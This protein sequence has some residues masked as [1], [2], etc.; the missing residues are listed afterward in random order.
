MVPTTPAI[1]PH[2]A[3]GLTVLFTIIYIAPFY[4]SPT[5]RSNS[6]ANR[7]TP[8]VIQA[9][10]RAVIWSCVTS[11]VITVCVLS[12]KGHVAPR[13]VLHLLG[14]YPVSILDTA[15][16]FLLVAILFAGPLFERAVVEGEWRSWGAVTVKETVYDDLIGWRNLVVGPV[17]EELVFRSLAISLFILAQTSAR[18]ITFT[19]P[20]IF[21]VAHVHHLHETINSS[22][23][24]GASYLSTALTPS[25]ILPGLIRSVFQF[26]YTSLFGFIAA[27]IYLRTSSLIACVLAH[28]F[29]NWM[30]LPRFWGRVGQEVGE[31]ILDQSHSADGN[32]ADALQAGTDDQQLSIIWT[33][34]Y[35]II[36][37]S[38]AIAFWKLRWSLTHSDSALTEF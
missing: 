15:K 21:G 7:N 19:S 27:F 18:R 4:L 37:F 11:V 6:I 28:S 3:G 1:S 29:C 31:E 22:R 13:E 24:P 32:V 2:V 33:I 5:L 20:L 30:G 36:L 34:A 38:G 12:F 8:S 35:Y 16:S 17:S 26:F 10:I 23:R 14:V 9:R 25:V